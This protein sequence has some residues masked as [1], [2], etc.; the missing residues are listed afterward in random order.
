[1][2]WSGVSW[3]V[4]L[5]SQF[6]CHDKVKYGHESHRIQNQEW[7]CW[8]GG[9]AICQTPPVSMKFQDSWPLFMHLRERVEIPQ[10]AA[11]FNLNKVSMHLSAAAE[12]QTIP[13]SWN[14][15]FVMMT[16]NACFKLCKRHCTEV[17][18]CIK[19]QSISHEWSSS[20]YSDITLVN[21]DWVYSQSRHV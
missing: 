5:L 3:R 19:R 9:A 20:A 10:C 14:L 13:W 1:M 6:Y 16:F 18:I 21:L 2:F 4:W 17:G 7:L 12:V 8:R 11:G 15:E